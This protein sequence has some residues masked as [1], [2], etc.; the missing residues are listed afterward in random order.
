MSLSAARSAK[1]LGAQIDPVF[2]AGER[3]ESMPGTLCLEQG[4]VALEGIVDGQVGFFEKG[5][6]AVGVD[7]AEGNCA[8]S[9]N[10]RDKIGKDTSSTLPASASC[11]FSTLPTASMTLRLRPDAPPPTRS[12]LKPH[13]EAVR[14]ESADMHGNTQ[15]RPERSCDHLGEALI[16]TCAQDLLLQDLLS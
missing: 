5:V 7:R 13:L 3:V 6:E 14:S 15:S 2:K 10:P 4:R 1:A 16:R 8:R 9:D 11:L 12:P